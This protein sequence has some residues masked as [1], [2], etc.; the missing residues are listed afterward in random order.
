VDRGALERVADLIAQRNAIDAQ[1]GAITGRPVVA[2]H[3]GEWIAAQIF[4]IDLE[5]SATAK[6]ID[7]RF[8]TGPLAG[9][10]VNVKLYGKREGI[11]DV[12]DDPLVEYYLVMT[13]PRGVAG[14]SLGGA[15]PILIDAVYLF[16]AD[17]ML[18][19]LRARGVKIG[20][21]T[22]LVASEWDAAEIFPTQTNVATQ[23]SAAQREALSLFS[24]IAHGRQEPA[25]S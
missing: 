11:L 22:S 2:G 19:A 24:E 15:R 18:D 14:S 8:T 21:A 25:V 20:V 9:S 10:T 13:G 1:I 17:P 5:A 23:L 12:V 16:Q 4:A 3:L 7:G 6:A